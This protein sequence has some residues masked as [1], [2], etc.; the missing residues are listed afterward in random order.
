MNKT[1]FKTAI[2]SA[3]ALIFLL[4]NFSNV[5][6]NFLIWE[7]ELPRA[8]HMAIAFAAGYLVS[9]TVKINKAA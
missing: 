5:P 2:I 7:I 4:Q 1:F 3:L 6:L 9:I 8:V